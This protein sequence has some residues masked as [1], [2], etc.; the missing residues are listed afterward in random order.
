[1][2][3]ILHLL[4]GQLHLIAAAPRHAP[5]WGLYGQATF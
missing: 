3:I 1:M 2:G 5:Q 4:G